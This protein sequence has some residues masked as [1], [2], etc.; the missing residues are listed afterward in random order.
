MKVASCGL[1]LFAQFAYAGL[2]KYPQLIVADKDPASSPT[3]SIRVTYLGVNGFQFE[4]GGHAL[5]VDPYFTC[6]GLW[7]G[8]LNERIEH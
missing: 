1:I 3:D 8:A 5:L 7:A 2:E 6:V 4:N